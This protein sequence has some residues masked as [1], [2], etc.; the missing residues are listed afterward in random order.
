MNV[1]SDQLLCELCHTVFY[2]DDRQTALNNSRPSP[3]SS[4]LIYIMCV[5]VL[6]D[7]FRCGAEGPVGR[8]KRGDGV[9]VRRE[10]G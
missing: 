1:A 3:S 5:C 6:N 9:R 7:I 2:D 4:D 8:E 10:G